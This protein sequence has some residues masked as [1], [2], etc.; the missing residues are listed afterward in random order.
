MSRG[1][2]ELKKNNQLPR[3]LA[4][5]TSKK[6]SSEINETVI[7]I[8]T[9]SFQLVANLAEYSVLHLTTKVRRPE[10]YKNYETLPTNKISHT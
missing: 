3:F 4:C 7:R 10:S 5:R 9:I 2:P 6:K 8:C 1:I